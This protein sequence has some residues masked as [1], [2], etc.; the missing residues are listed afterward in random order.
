MLEMEQADGT[1]V[2]QLEEKLVPPILDASTVGLLSHHAS[3]IE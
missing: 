1:E 3:P 2:E